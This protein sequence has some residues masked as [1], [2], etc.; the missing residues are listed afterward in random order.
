MY[1][2]VIYP[3]RHLLYHSH[4][5][6]T[7]KYLGLI[8]VL[9][10]R[11]KNASRASTKRRRD[12]KLN[13]PRKKQ[14]QTT[15]SAQAF[16][17]KDTPYHPSSSVSRYTADSVPKTE[18][19]LKPKPSVRKVPRSAENNRRDPFYVLNDE[20]RLIISLLPARDTET[21]RRVSK[22]WKAS[23]EFHCGKSAL[24]KHFPWAASKVDEFGSRE[25]ANLLFRRY[26]RL[27]P[28]MYLLAHP[29]FW[30]LITG[31]Y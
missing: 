23:S 7:A 9:A 10:F 11:M 1:L 25:E 24:L 17:V 6:S 3:R 20:V 26:C 16:S 30:Y 4:P 12:S 2:T 18:P 22:L 5:C 29:F 14:E 8:A 15:A 28:F 19:V 13:K 21:L 27:F 31:G